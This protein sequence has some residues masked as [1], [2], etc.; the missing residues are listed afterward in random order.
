V[1]GVGRDS[2][3][4]RRE[5]VERCLQVGLPPQV[6]QAHVVIAADAGSDVLEGDWLDHDGFVPHPRT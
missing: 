3:D 1:H 5:F 6:E 4:V 2:D